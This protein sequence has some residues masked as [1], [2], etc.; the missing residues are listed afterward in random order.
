MPIVYPH[1]T[2][3]A[4]ERLNKKY[5]TY[6]ASSQTTVKYN[7]KTIYKLA[8][9]L[10][11]FRS[12]W[13][14]D[15]MFDMSNITCD[16]VL[17]FIALIDNDRNNIRADSEDDKIKS[18]KHRTP[19]AIH[20]T[21]K[22]LMAL[23]E[24]YNKTDIYSDI[25]VQ[26][27]FNAI[28]KESYDVRKTALLYDTIPVGMT[29]NDLLEKAHAMLSCNIE[30]DSTHILNMKLY[31]MFLI[32]LPPMRLQDYLSASY[33]PAAKNYMDLETSTY[34][35][36]DFKTKNV[37]AK[38]YDDGRRIIDIPEKLVSYM[39]IM[40]EKYSDN[41]NVFTSKR[42]CS[43]TSST[44]R[45]LLR[46]Y[47]GLISTQIRILFASFN[48]PNMAIDEIVKTAYIMGHTVRT[49]QRDYVRRLDNIEI[50]MSSDIQIQIAKI[51]EA[52]TAKLASTSLESSSQ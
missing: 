38:L 23:L 27:M 43:Y 9:S 3:D 7:I 6:V 34:I 45:S 32:Y 11:Q 2:T 28:E 20:T 52:D 41:M 44:F 14:A 1:V 10:P 29:W 31:A 48:V 19:G 36:T 22:Y 21:C 13:C 33:D 24:A 25:D 8:Y 37:F 35:I 17:D 50:D 49:Q 4:N 16:D 51:I 30:F 5:Q 26:D 18:V 15:D 42:Q 12:I 47:F 46:T 39:R 40:R